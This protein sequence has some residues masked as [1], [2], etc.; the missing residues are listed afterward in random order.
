M[1]EARQRIPKQAEAALL[2]NNDHTCCICVDRS[3][4]VQIHHIDSDETNNNPG[5]LAVLCLDCHSRV[6]GTRGLGK[7]YSALEVKKYKRHW[8]YVV[9]RKR[10][11]A[12]GVVHPP[13]RAERDAF[14]FEIK[15]NV[16]LLTTIRSEARA[17]EML[18]FLQTY[19]ILQGD[20]SYVI[21]QLH[22]AAPFFGALGALVSE[23]VP[24]Y[25]G[26]LPG[27][28]DI[29][30][31]QKDIQNLGDGIELLH[32]LLQLGIFGMGVNQIRSASRALCDI[33]EI[34]QSYSLRKLEAKIADHLEDAKQL[35]QEHF[36]L[37]RAEEAVASEIIQNTLEKMFG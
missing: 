28:K 37:S 32:W 8:E 15:R 2:F 10:K 35:L 36:G 13:K 19:T 4:D 1:T 26:G 33:F 18:D 7:K 27:P 20:E 21:Q 14:R 11:L 16:Y 9:I 24:R 3:K 31:R 23:Y 6:T 17:K 12:A 30:I 22:E 29:P 25:F 34:T 5:N